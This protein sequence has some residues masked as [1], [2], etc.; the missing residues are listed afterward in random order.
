MDYATSAVITDYLIRQQNVFTL[1]EFSKFLKSKSVKIT[2][3]QA[4]DIL[5]SSNYVFPLVNDEYVTRAGVFTNRWFSIKPSKEEI[6]K[7][8]LLIGHRC[9]PFVNPDVAP[10]DIHITT[11]KGSI[12]PTTTFFT[13]NLAMDVFA[14]FGEGYVLPYII[15][16]KA[17][18]SV[19]LTSVQYSLPNEIELTSW[20]LSDIAG[21]KMKYGD[22][23]LCRVIDWATSTVEVSVIWHNHK[24]SEE[25]TLTNDDIQRENWYIDFENG[26]MESFDRNGPVS[27][28]EEQLSL[29][30]L[31]HQEE[32]CIKNCGSSEEFLAHTKKIGFSSYGVE[33]RIW[34]VNET[35]PYV[36]EWNKNFSS[37]LII[38]EMSVTFSPQI[39]DSYLNNYLYEKN[40]QKKNIELEE[41]INKIFPTVIKMSPAERKLVLLNIEK[42]N[43]ILEKQY[44]QFF[45]FEIAP[46][47]QRVIELFSR[48][49]FLM[50]SI[51]CSKVKVEKF[52]QQELVILTQLFG[53]IVK[54]LEE[55][56]NVY[57]RGS[58]PVDDIMLSLDGMEDTFDDIEVLLKRSLDI[59][60]RNGFE[61]VK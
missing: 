46:L 45:D 2:K 55:L 31:E 21:K 19:P 57:I 35:V 56:E 53:H 6:L 50:C 3:V 58:I 17:N 9:M 37:E 39:V 10:E 30:F 18:Q 22:R 4:A 51:G 52:P 1:D 14:L 29:L 36:G 12:F 42:R 41:V 49:S 24:S 61:L 47:R 28:I 34:R 11:P 40:K 27:S 20:K 13:M 23:L 59:N 60:I 44:S 7:D 48:V 33:T 15:N 16:D 32:L 8:R 43:A 25:L 26:L 54:I 38:S 5:R